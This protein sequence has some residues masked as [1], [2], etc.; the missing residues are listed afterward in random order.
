MDVAVFDRETRTVYL[1]EVKGHRRY[2][3]DGKDAVDKFAAYADAFGWD[4]AGNVVVFNET[5]RRNGNMLLIGN[6]E[7]KTVCDTRWTE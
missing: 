5:A 3:E 1:T 6:I 7:G 2:M 4:V